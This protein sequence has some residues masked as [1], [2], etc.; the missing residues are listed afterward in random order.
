MGNLECCLKFFQ[1]GQQGFQPCAFCNRADLNSA[2]VLWWLQIN[3]NSGNS[4]Y[5]PWLSKLACDGVLHGICTLPIFVT[6]FC[7]SH[8]V[9][10]SEVWKRGRSRSTQAIFAKKGSSLK[11]YQNLVL[12]P[13]HESS[14]IQCCVELKREAEA[15]EYLMILLDLQMDLTLPWNSL[16]CQSG[17]SK[18]FFSLHDYHCC[19]PMLE[20]KT[21]FCLDSVFIFKLVQLW[22]QECL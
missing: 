17:L 7:P 13:I 16:N 8:I 1:R 6:G 22:S 4:I 11:S 21:T 20:E 9:I 14:H 15:G 2:F 18:F 19:E 12:R 5:L 10:E 3:L